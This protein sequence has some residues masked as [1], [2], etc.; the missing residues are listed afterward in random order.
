MD[1]DGFLRKALLKTQT[2]DKVH[3]NFSLLVAGNYLHIN[4]MSVGS[5]E[6]GLVNLGET[7]I[8]KFSAND[9][10]YVNGN[11]GGY[12][13]LINWR[14]PPKKWHKVS[15][16][17]VLN[18]RVSPDIFKDKIVL[19]GATASSL[20]DLFNVPYYRDLFIAPELVSGVEIQ[21]N[22]IKHLIDVGTGDRTL[23]KTIP[24]LWEWIWLGFWLTTLSGIL[25]SQTGN[26]KPKYTTNN[27]SENK[28]DSDRFLGVGFLLS[29]MAIATILSLFLFGTTYSAFALSKIWLPVIP[30][31]LAIFG[32]M[33]FTPIAIY[34]D[35]IKQANE[36]IKQ[37]NKRLNFKV[38]QRTQELQ[39]SNTELKKET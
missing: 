38:R 32:A 4:G 30:P 25:I 24:D 31:A 35:K 14:S 23:I 3:L 19:I 39:H 37:A 34:I 1:P 26:E 8:E 2:K 11:D 33:V 15:L 7:T 29:A 17:H 12:Q 22:I 21:A 13:I 9:G 18:D 5:T 16:S 20:N 10:G 36:E 27:T 28:I 6:S